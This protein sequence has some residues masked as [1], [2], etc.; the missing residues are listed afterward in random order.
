VQFFKKK[1]APNKHESQKETQY[2]KMVGE[3]LV[4]MLHQVL[5]VIDFIQKI[6]FLLLQQILDVKKI[7]KGLTSVLHRVLFVKALWKMISMWE[8]FWRSSIIRRYIDMNL[9]L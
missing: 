7:Y 6:L 8:Q 4:W 5:E 2:V 3:I 1:Q 9:K